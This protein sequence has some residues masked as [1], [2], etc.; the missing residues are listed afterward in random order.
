MSATVD[1]LKFS[2]YFGDCPVVQVPGRTFPVEVR[3]LEDVVEETEYFLEEDSPFAKR[4]Q[5]IQKGTRKVKRTYQ[6]T[7]ND[8]ALIGSVK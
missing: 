3:F 4:L 7:C 8:C 1:A 6:L 5:R 2:S